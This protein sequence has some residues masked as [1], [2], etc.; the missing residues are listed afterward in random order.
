MELRHLR[1]FAMVAEELHFAR[2]AERLGIEQSPLSH[3]IRNLEAELGVRLFH[4]TTRRTWLTRAGA[5]FYRDVTGILRDIELAKA[6]LHN[7]LQDEPR[8]IRLALGEYLADESFS[9]LLND[10]EQ[11]HLSPKVQVQEC[12]H[13]EAARLIREKGADVALTFNGRPAS[14]LR[15]VRGWGEPLVFVA[16]IDHALA[17]R[18]K[19]SLVDIASECLALPLKSTCPGYLLQIEQLFERHRLAINHR[20]T[21]MHW[22]TGV[23]FAATGRAVSLVPLSYAHALSSV[24]VIPIQE[25]DAEFVT[26]LFYDEAYTS[27]AVSLVLE[28][29]ELIDAGAGA[30]FFGSA[31]A[32]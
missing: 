3:S 16:S 28:A 7:H 8:T 15:L 29:A 22:N 18:E 30:G 19:V 17:E 25:E 11:N 13:P 5:R 10:L 1:H 6:A 24:V 26:W 31:G 21:I 20:T 32:E 12:S 4:R 27:S 9:R 14:G 23:S 2:A